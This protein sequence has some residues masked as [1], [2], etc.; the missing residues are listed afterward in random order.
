MCL[1]CPGC[2]LATVAKQQP[3]YTLIDDTR[4]LSKGPLKLNTS[5]DES[6]S[7][8][9]NHLLV[10]WIQYHGGGKLYYILDF[11]V[12]PA[13]KD[14][15]RSVALS[16]VSDSSCD[17][18]V[19]LPHP[20]SFLVNQVTLEITSC[21]FYLVGQWQLTSS[22]DLFYNLVFLAW[23]TKISGFPICHGNSFSF[24]GSEPSLLNVVEAG[25]VTISIF[26]TYH[27]KLL[28]SVH[29]DTLQSI[30]H[31]F[32]QSIFHSFVPRPHGN[33]ATFSTMPDL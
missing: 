15:Q 5:C 8:L 21:W 19:N 6:I 3:G 29:V 26:H 12:F 18:L 33:E 17:A 31:S 22:Y 13:H 7:F 2:C 20:V 32:M 23:P 30:F 11:S 9:A 4:R 28:C 24:L 27:I 10:T 1:L 16:S 14:L 25:M